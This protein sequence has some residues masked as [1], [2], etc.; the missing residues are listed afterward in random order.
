VAGWAGWGA[1]PSGAGAAGGPS[2]GFLGVLAV[3]SAG[4]AAVLL[5]ER[6]H[7]GALVAGGA[8]AY[9][10]LRALGALGRRKGGR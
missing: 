9:F 4:A 1:G 2:R 7:A 3:V 6:S 10:A 8:A 5:R